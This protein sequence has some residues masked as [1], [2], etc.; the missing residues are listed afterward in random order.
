MTPRV[1]SSS[2][3]G[4]PRKH[5]GN[6]KGWIPSEVIS[7]NFYRLHKF[8]RTAITQKNTDF[9]E[10]WKSADSPSIYWAFP[11][12]NPTSSLFQTYETVVSNAW[13]S[14]FKHM[15]QLFQESETVDSKL[16]AL[17]MSL[18]EMDAQG[19]VTC[20]WVVESEARRELLLER[21]QKAGKLTSGERYSVPSALETGKNGETAWLSANKS[22]T[23]P[24]SMDSW[25]ANRCRQND[26]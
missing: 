3:L 10:T 22:V 6:Y 15:K 25:T 20:I 8:Y 23:L 2:N 16:D 11:M 7:P 4:Y 26:G 21:I 19:L 12:Q 17:G 14:C 5:K 24:R 1:V 18:F 13:N 9:E